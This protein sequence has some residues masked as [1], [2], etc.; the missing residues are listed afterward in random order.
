MV[1]TGNE[2]KIAK[3]ILEIGENNGSAFLVKWRSDRKNPRQLKTSKAKQRKQLIKKAPIKK[4][5][6]V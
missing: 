3:S 4:G 6:H 2:I 1:W 5:T